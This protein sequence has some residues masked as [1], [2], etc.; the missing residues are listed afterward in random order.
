MQRILRVYE[1]YLRSR[2]VSFLV[3]IVETILI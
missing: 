1:K 2:S 3:Q